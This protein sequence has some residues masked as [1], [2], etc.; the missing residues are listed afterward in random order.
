M[1]V[2]EIEMKSLQLEPSDKEIND[3]INQIGRQKQVEFFTQKEQEQ[4]EAERKNDYN[5]ASQLALEMI[6]IKKSL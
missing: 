1:V 5:L 3:Y 6:E 4:K 2:T